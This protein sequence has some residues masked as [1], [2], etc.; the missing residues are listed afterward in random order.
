MTW[1]IIVGLLLLGLLAWRSAVRTA[2][3]PKIGDIAPAFSLPDQN[4]NRRELADFSGKH[5][6]LYFFPRADTPG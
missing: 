3:L 2:D 5:L 4:G 1:L 6:V